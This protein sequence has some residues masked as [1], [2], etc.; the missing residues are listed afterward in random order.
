[1]GGPLVPLPDRRSTIRAMGV[2]ACPA[3]GREF[4]KRQAHYCAPAMT[5]DDFFQGRPAAEREIFEA[6][7]QHLE[8]LGPVIVEPVGVGIL[9]KG[10]RTFVELRPR[11]RWWDL[12]FGLNR[13]V[14]HPR[15][16]RTVKTKT[17]RTYHGTR[18]TSAADVD[19]TVREW[20]TE[21][22]LDLAV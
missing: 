8:S 16:S 2:W 13:R 21:S 7:R 9:F 10:V 6:V 11:A 15:I 18:L 3:C 4:G 12:S 1:M 22:Y 14:H 5:P 19:D 20:L 17:A